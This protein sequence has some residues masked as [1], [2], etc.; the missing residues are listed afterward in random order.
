MAIVLALAAA[1]PW[2]SAKT[3]PPWRRISIARPATRT[4]SVVVSSIARPSKR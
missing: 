3:S 4:S 1:F 2:R